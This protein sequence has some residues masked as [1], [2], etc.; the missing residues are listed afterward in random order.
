MPWDE[1]TAIDAKEKVFLDKAV[2]CAVWRKLR[3]VLALYPRRAAS[4][5]MSAAARA[6][7]YVFAAGVVRAYPQ[8]TD[9]VVGNEPNQNRFWQPQA[10]VGAAYEAVLADAYDGIKA[11]RRKARVLGFANSGRGNDR[12]H[13]PSNASTS[14][15]LFIHD[16]AVATGERPEA[17]ADGRVRLLLVADNMC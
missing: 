3:V 17:A 10:G 9:F 11:V 2:P 13:S 16:A 12:P 14:P 15:E 6:D 5:G 7:F 8:V 4:V 1:G